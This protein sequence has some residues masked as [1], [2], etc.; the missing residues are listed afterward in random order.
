MKTQIAEKSIIEK[1]ETYLM[2]TYG[3]FPVVF[4]DGF[5]STLIDKDGRKYTDFLSGIAVTNLGYS[6]E[7]VKAVM[8]N[9][10]NTIIHTSN[11]FHIE[12]QGE[13]GELLCNHSFAA[14]VFF[15][16]SG[17]EANEGAIKLARKRAYL[18]YGE[19]KNEI[20]AMKGSF[21]GR[22]LA[23]LNMTDNPLYREGYGPHPAGFVFTPFNDVEALITAVNANTAAIILEPLQGEGG[24]YPAQ[25]NFMK[26]AR[27]L[28]DQYDCAL[29]FDEVQCGMGRTGKL[30]AHEHYGIE[31][32][33]MTLAKALANGVPIGAILA[34]GDFAETFKP[35]DHGTTFGGNHLAT[36]AGKATVEEIVDNDLAE[37]AA[38]KGV[39]LKDKL[40][41]LCQK[42]TV[43]TEVRGLGLLVGMELTVPGQ[44]IVEAMFA[45]GYLINC[46]QKNIL[47]FMPPFTITKMEIDAMLV[48]LQN[49]LGSGGISS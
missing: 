3:R 7:K 37:M 30:F 13:L 12:S 5:D 23:T 18:K 32:D 44:P 11:N 16:N 43:V 36:A 40:S 41:A 39:Y 38:Q 4:V 48:A 20:V 6:N 22:T 31:P 14:K 17:A 19:Q 46:T 9:Q 45:K 34:K 8:L 49:V 10:V 28:A 27:E 42:S 26:K 24:I 35:G 2:G 15:G 29:I 47:R 25:M 21:H 33:I 1:S